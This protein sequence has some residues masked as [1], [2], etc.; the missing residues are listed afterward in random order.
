MFLILMYNQVIFVV[1]QTWD[2]AIHSVYANLLDA[3]KGVVG[4]PASGSIVKSLAKK[5]D[6]F[7]HRISFAAAF[8]ACSPRKCTHQRL[9]AS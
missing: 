7:Q 8:S 3:V 2:R 6:Y 4:L 1:M 9:E 5:K